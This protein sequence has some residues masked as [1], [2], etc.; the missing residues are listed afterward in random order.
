MEKYL[1]EENYQKG[2]KK[3]QTI[4]LTILVIGFLIGSIL[5]A[6]G[7]IK[8]SRVNSQYS[9]EN[10]INISQQLE[11]ERQKLINNKSKLEAKGIKYNTFAE[12]TDGESYDL[13]VITKVLDPSLDN[14]SRNE[15][16]TNS[17]TYKYCSLEN[18]LKNLNNDVLEDIDASSSI[19]F[20]A[21][22]IIAIFTGFVFGSVVYVMSK[23]REITA[24]SV[25]QTIPIAKEEIDEMAPS[26]RNAAREIA[27]GIKKGL[28]DNDKE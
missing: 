2:K 11:T 23:G 19:G 4:S 14:C 27:T 8:Q 9:E 7:F 28:S 16:K 22:G 25:Q 18:K 3:L 24:F 12:Y 20:Y 1:S 5:I 15:Y 13:Y 26:I 21:I 17:L 6:T 10:K